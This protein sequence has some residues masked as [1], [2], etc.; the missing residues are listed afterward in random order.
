MCNISLH[1]ERYYAI[2][3][4]MAY[5]IDLK[6]KA[7]KAHLNGKPVRVVGEQFGVGHGSVARWASELKANGTILKTK[8][9]RVH[10]RKITEEKI[11]VFLEKNPTASQIDMAEEFECTPQSVCIALI[12]FNYSKKT[13]EDIQRTL[14]YKASKLC[15]RTIRICWQADSLP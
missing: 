7:A 3:I 4:V 10:L 8:P 15:Q 14:R 2:I 11:E 5:S 13:T 1:L 6:T 12:K 9:N